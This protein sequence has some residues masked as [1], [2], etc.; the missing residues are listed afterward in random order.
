MDDDGAGG[1]DWRMLLEFV[2]DGGG[3]SIA[4]I[5][6][7]DGV[8]VELHGYDR[9]H[10][11]P[12]DLAHAVTERELGLADGVF[13]SIAGGA[14]FASVRVRS[15][16]QRYDAAAR[17]K[18]ILDMNQRAL[19]VAEVMAGIV[20]DAF[21]H[22][23]GGDPYEKGR[24]D[25]AIVCPDPYPWSADDI[26]GAVR[27]LSEVAAEWQRDGRVELFWPDRL[28]S[29]VPVERGIKRGRTGRR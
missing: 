29:R 27:K 15:G 11:V 25:W 16:R 6:R 18:R 24:I 3:S 28:V 19:T 10:R 26:A 2:S 20:H 13:G 9:R 21:E 1:D 14:F 5:P 23:G 12:H 17:S 22:P 8:V 4:I 7:N